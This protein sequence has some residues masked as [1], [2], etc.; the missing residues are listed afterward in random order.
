MSVY[1]RHKEKNF[2]CI[3]NHLFEDKTLSMKAKG[4]LATILS[5]PDNWKYSVNGLASLF[6][7]GRDAVN[8]AINEL[9]DHG[10]IVRTKSVNEFGMFEGYIYDI[11]EKPQTENGK[12]ADIP[13]TEEPNTVKPFTDNSALSNTNI[14]N[15]NISNTNSINIL[16]E[17][18]KSKFVPPTLEEVFAYCLERQNGINPQ[19]FI[20]YYEA[21]GWELSKGRKVRDWR[22]CVRTWES[23]A[24]QRRDNQ[25]TGNPFDGIE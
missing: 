1:R 7:D 11:Y 16:G 19:H 22:A 25:N 2:T 24:K 10:Y 17:P 12:V 5:L 4:L 21:R 20:D 18:K 23:N 6:S 13:F 3:D 8:G 14:L 15:T 9:I